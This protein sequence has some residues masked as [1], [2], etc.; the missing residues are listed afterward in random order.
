MYVFVCLQV[1]VC[2]YIQDRRRIYMDE[3]VPPS[4]AELLPRHDKSIFEQCAS[5]KQLLLI[6]QIQ[7]IGNWV[8]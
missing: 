6:E 5:N 2:E 4:A 1:D 8:G 3:C 7:D